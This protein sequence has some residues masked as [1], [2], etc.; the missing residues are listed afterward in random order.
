MAVKK[1]GNVPLLRQI[2][3][4]LADLR[5]SGVYDKIFTKYFG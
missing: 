4:S 1:D 5:D 3:G 2:N